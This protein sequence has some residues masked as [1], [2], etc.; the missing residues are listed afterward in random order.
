MNLIRIDNDM[1]DLSPRM[2]FMIILQ[3]YVQSRSGPV[4]LFHWIRSF[5]AEIHPEFEAY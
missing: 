5:Q 1:S 3:T 2:L 4:I